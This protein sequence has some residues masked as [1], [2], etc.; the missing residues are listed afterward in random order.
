MY[1]ASVGMP[2]YGLNVT[3]R[4]NHS[5]NGLIFYFAI[6]TILSQNKEIHKDIT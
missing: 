3:N 6:E 2:V 4:I 1:V 5:F